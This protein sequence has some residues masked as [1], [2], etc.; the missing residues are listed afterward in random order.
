MTAIFVLVLT[1]SYL[2]MATQASSQQPRRLLARNYG[3]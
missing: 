3:A 1:M 2:M